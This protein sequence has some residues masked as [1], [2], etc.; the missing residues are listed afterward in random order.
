M[1]NNWRISNA[2]LQNLMTKNSESHNSASFLR[3]NAENGATKFKFFSDSERK[4]VMTF[5]QA[6][7]KFVESDYNFVS[8]VNNVLLS[9]GNGAIFL[10]CAPFSAANI[11]KKQFE[12]VIMPALV[13]DRNKID[14]V[15]FFDKFTNSFN[16][17]EKKVTVF[18]NLDRTS[19][20]IVPCP[21]DQRGDLADPK[22]IRRGYD[23][24]QYMTHLTS[25]IGGP[26]DRTG[27]CRASEPHR[28]QVAS[29][30]EALGKEALR[31]SDAAARSK[32]E[33]KLAFVRFFFLFFQ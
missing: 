4:N 23:H 11:D 27:E 30:W 9:N 8:L 12:F 25:F 5:D 26:K 20:L 14:I 18:Q 31:L 21:V 32:D 15:P 10:E 29:L 3:C 6:L 22:T 16:S 28:T 19:S 2:G 1:L 13:L 24:L 17:P 7:R 33:G